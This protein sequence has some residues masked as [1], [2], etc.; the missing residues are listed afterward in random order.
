MRIGASF[1]S[2]HYTMLKYN[3]K[4]GANFEVNSLEADYN[5]IVSHTNAIPGDVLLLMML[6]SFFLCTQL[7][8]S[9][10][11]TEPHFY[12]CYY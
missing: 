12:Y 11:I 9:A 1:L 2:T 6:F 4:Q 8:L 7:N 3:R 5:I 10:V